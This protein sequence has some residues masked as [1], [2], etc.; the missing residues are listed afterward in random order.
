MR[1]TPDY[2]SM[3][4]YP[5]V[6]PHR[7][8]LKQN[9][10][11][12]IQRNI[13]VEKG[14]VINARVRSASSF[15]KVQLINT[16]ESRCIPCINFAFHSNRS[17]WTVNRR[18]FP[19]RP[20]YATTFNGYQGST[21]TRTVLDFRTDPFTHGQLYTALSRVRTRRDTRCLFAETNESQD[22]ANIVFTELLL[23]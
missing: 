10:V 5:G 14:L 2:L 21:L 8:D 15:I 19:L 9:C 4:T 20:A 17:S 13:S 12:A 23:L 22:S 1:H 11:C 16:F 7:L 6:P 18:Q 3:L